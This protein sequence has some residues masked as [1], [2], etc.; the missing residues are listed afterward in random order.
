MFYAL[1]HTCGKCCGSSRTVYKL[2]AYE[3]SCMD[4]S[5]NNG[6]LACAARGIGGC[7]LDWL[8]VAAGCAVMGI[9]IVV[10]GKTDRIKEEHN[11]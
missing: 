2:Q 8:L 7:V 1:A 9:E 5:G 10:F 4:H 3:E 6:S 11:S